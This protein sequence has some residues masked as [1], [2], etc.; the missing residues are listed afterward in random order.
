MRLA[1]I[2]TLFFKLPRQIRPKRQAVLQQRA[3]ADAQLHQANLLQVC[4]ICI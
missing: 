4:Q 3:I 2:S 1:I